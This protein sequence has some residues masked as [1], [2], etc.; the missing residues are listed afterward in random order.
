MIFD[1]IYRL[2]GETAIIREDA[3]KFTA[4]IPFYEFVYLSRDFELAEP[5]AS[6]SEGNICSP[7]RDFELMPNGIMA[8]TC[9]NDIYFSE[10]YQN[11][12]YSIFSRISLPYN[13]VKLGVAGSSLIAVTREDV[14][15]IT[16]TDPQLMSERKLNI[17]QGCLSQQGAVDIGMQ[18]LVYPSPDG[19]IMVSTAGVANLTKALYERVQWLGLKPENFHAVFHNGAYFCIHQET[20][21]DDEVKG[22]IVRPDLQGGVGQLTELEIDK[23]EGGSLVGVETDDLTDNILMFRNISKKALDDYYEGEFFDEEVRFE[24][25]YSSFF[26]NRDTV[27]FRKTLALGADKSVVVFTNQNVLYNDIQITI[28]LNNKAN[29]YYGLRY[30]RRNMNANPGGKMTIVKGHHT[31]IFQTCSNAA[32]VG[33]VEVQNGEMVIVHIIGGNRIFFSS[34]IVASEQGWSS[35]HSM[36]WD[37]INVDGVDIRYTCLRSPVEDGL[38][39]LDLVNHPYTVVGAW[40]DPD[41]SEVYTYKWVSKE[42]DMFTFFSP[43]ELRVDA[44]PA[45]NVDYGD[46]DDDEHKSL[47]KVTV[48]GYRDDVGERGRMRNETPS[49]NHT[50]TIGGKYGGV[51]KLP[52]NTRARYFTITIESN[53][54]VTNVVLAD[55]KEELNVGLKTDAK[56]D[57]ST[58]SQ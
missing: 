25:A 1:G 5:I 36:I 2:V 6:I 33:S 31:Q 3:S 32:P 28:P 51:V 52:N 48:E 16:G 58:I 21:K 55:S 8:I 4:P 37:G 19:L 45:E 12:K 57:T 46:D 47:L 35:L 34:P 41:S 20:I 11:Y 56:K 44:I 53:L 15:E 39:A 38:N 24:S 29:H 10:P 9:L 42:F 18:G 30:I 27:D 17:R 23:G 54:V 13:V 22:F 14:Y 43:K 7:A 26:Q 50:S 49:I 40:D